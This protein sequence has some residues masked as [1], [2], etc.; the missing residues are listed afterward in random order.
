MSER[1]VYHDHL[2][3][4]DWCRSHPFDLCIAGSAAL[5]LAA[6]GA[7]R[8]VQVPRPFAVYTTD[9]LPNEKSPAGKL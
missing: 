2:D 5:Q 1:N 6:I 9:A 8:E 3:A 4:C 7:I